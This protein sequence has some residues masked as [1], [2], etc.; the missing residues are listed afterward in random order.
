MGGASANLGKA[1]PDGCL[2]K[3][4]V[5][6][7]MDGKGFCYFPILAFWTLLG[8]LIGRRFQWLKKRAAE[9]MA[10]LIFHK[11]VLPGIAKL[12]RLYSKGKAEKIVKMTVVWSD[13]YM[14][15]LGVATKS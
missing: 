12:R 8:R 10:R 5:H 9:Q 15:D 11:R 6:G 3:G 14:L 13:W 1:V 2:S 7:V 4:E